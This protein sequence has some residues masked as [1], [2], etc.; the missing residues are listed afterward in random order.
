MELNDLFPA[1]ANRVSLHGQEEKTALKDWISSS[2]AN[3]DKLTD[4]GDQAVNQHGAVME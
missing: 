2:N 3:F 4:E 1:I